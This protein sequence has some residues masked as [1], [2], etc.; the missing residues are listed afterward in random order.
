MKE[1]EPVSLPEPPQGIP[2][3][4]TRSKNGHR[5]LVTQH[6]GN[7]SLP[8]RV[9]KQGTVHTT[10]ASDPIGKAPVAMNVLLTNFMF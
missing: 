1:S 2:A 7:A 8:E 6:I 9:A 4:H 3:A 5:Q 10:Q